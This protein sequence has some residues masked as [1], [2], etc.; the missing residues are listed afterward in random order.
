MAD[1]FHDGLSGDGTIGG[2]KLPIEGS[3]ATAFAASMLSLVFLWFVL[4]V[5][6]IVRLFA[7][8]NAKLIFG[9][10]STGPRGIDAATRA[11]TDHFASRMGRLHGLALGILVLTSFALG[12]WALVDHKNEIGTN[13][14][15]SAMIDQMEN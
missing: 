1:I 7:N 6:L 5:A 8:G 4:F 3:V 14:K 12:L 2:R 10:E 11:I 9:M 13:G 15:T